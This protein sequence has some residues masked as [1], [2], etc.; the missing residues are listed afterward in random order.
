M[1]FI[2]VNGALGKMGSLICQRILFESD[3]SLTEAFENESHPALNQD[4]GIA[5]AIEE[6]KLNVV[7]LEKDKNYKMN[8]LV[9][10]SSKTGFSKVLDF[11]VSKKIAMVSGTTGLDE[12]QV[13]E[14][15]DASKIIPILYSSNMSTGINTLLL[16][17]DSMKDILCDYQRDVEI[18]EYHHNQKKDAPSG[19]AL[20]IAQKISEI[21]KRKIDFSGQNSFPRSSDVR[22]HSLRMGAIPG[23][24]K[25]IIS[26]NGETIEISHSADT[27]DTFAV[28]AI[29]A[30][31]FISK[32]NKGL[33]NMVDLLK[34]K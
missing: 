5:L 7:K 17:L 23:F 31:R 8:I 25:I 24:H 19:T 14:M 26:G 11:C 18:I 15:K 22:I 3:I 34:E 27:R 16:S 4:L 6:W 32:K 29:K 1:L 2:G 33:F 13:L 21:S 10:F 30:V 28:G 12:K 9:D 20:T